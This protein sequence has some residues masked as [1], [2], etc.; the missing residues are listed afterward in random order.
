[1][2]TTSM[3]EKLFDVSPVTFPA[4]SQTEC[5]VRSMF[6]IMRN[7]QKEVEQSKESNKRKLEMQKQKLKFIGD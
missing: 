2:K 4:Y 1:M 6:D 7:H 3:S 5:G